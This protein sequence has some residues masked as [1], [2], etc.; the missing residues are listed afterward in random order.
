MELPSLALTVFFIF[1][2]LLL[3]AFNAFFVAAEFAIVKV[4]RTRLEELVGQG[5]SRARIAIL[6]VDQLDE[7]LS[8][9]QLGITLVSLGLGWIGEEAFFNLFVILFPETLSSGVFHL[10]ATGCSFFIIT[11]LHVV[12]GELVPKSMA[13][14]RAEEIT[15]RVTAPLRFFYKVAKPMIRFFTIISNF[16]LHLIGY[17]GLEEEPLS[18]EELKMVVQESHEGG[19]ISE[20]EAQI[21]NRAFSFA[22][23]RTIDIMIPM[24]RVQ[25]FSLKKTF[26]QNMQIAKNKMHTRFP[27]VS[28]DTSHIVGV[29]HLKDVFHYETEE[30]TNQIFEKVAR[31]PFFVDS[32]LR[33]DQLMKLLKERRVHLAIVQDAKTKSNIGIVTMEDILE[34]LVGE[35]FDEHGN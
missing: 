24:S 28:D 30:W 6:T 11:M 2:S 31:P 10:I 32:S 35:I 1:L 23:K 29:V 27:L 14:Q 15:L 33:Q 3:V 4:R 17:R 13:I 26:D 18:E 20:S 22:D 12:L 8:A 9:T 16:L 25:C 5:V 21:I 19:V 34:G 7:Y